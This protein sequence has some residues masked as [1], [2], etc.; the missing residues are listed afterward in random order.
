ML[1]AGFGFLILFFANAYLSQPRIFRSRRHALP[2]ARRATAYAQG[3]FRLCLHGGMVIAAFVSI[4][5][6]NFATPIFAMAFMFHIQ[7]KLAGRRVEL[8]EPVR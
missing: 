2:A 1:F 8:I 6:L 3:Q 4:P 7:K 5:L